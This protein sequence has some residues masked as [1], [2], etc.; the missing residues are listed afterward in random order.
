M[1]PTAQAGVHPF[2]PDDSG[3]C[4]GCG[5]YG[6]GSHW[7][8]SAR[9][10]TKEELRPFLH[11]MEEKTLPAIE[12]A[13][14]ERARAAAKARNTV[15]CARPSQ[16]MVEGQLEPCTFA[17][18]GDWLRAHEAAGRLSSDPRAVA[19]AL[20]SQSFNL[21]LA[22]VERLLAGNFTPDEI[23]G[24]CHN[25]PQTVPVEEFAAGCAA[26]QRQLYGCA[27]DADQ[28]AEP[29]SCTVTPIYA[30]EEGDGPLVSTD[31][32]LR[33]RGVSL[34]VNLPAG[35]RG[36]YACRIDTMPTVAGKL[37]P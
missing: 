17:E 21:L 4:L 25:L 24:F 29:V 20:A 34:L 22:L 3:H 2:Q 19:L 32:F 15:L 23:Q 9:P 33:G 11:E 12:Q 14:R 8:H 7:G 26:Y 5:G 18:F 31:L 36:T 1:S 30:G 27:P 6:H 10:V 37:G 35:S 28:L 16:R 13:V